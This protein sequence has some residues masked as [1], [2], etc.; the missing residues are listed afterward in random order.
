MI[1]NFFTVFTVTLIC[2]TGALTVKDIVEMY[3][4]QGYK[5]NPKYLKFLYFALVLLNI[6]VYFYR[7]PI[8][9]NSLI[10]FLIFIAITFFYESNLQNR[11][12]VSLFITVILFAFELIF[13]YII[14]VYFFNSVEQLM[15]Y[16]ELFS[17]IFTLTRLIPFVI[18]KII[19]AIRNI[20]SNNSNNQN[21]IKIKL[22]DWCLLCSVP[23]ISLFI[24]NYLVT[25]SW[26]IANSVNIYI[27]LIIGLII[28]LNIVFY[29]LYIRTL[30]SAALMAKSMLLD[31]QIE[32]Y[33]SEYEKL[34]Y[35]IQ[36]INTIKHDVKHKLLM[37][38]SN[39]ERENIINQVLDDTFEDVF[40]S[41]FICYTNNSAMDMVLN[42]HVNKG[43]ESGALLKVS[44]DIFKEIKI[45]SKIFCVVLGNVLDNAREACIL[46]KT[47]EINLSIVQQNDNLFI[48][49]E[50][51]FVGEVEFIDGLPRTTKAD[52]SIHGIGLSSVAKMTEENGGYFNISI[53]E[54]IFSVQILLINQ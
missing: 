41:G 23:I 51:E 5:Q 19:R 47:K 7:I 43:E 1:F 12:F 22:L 42:Y 53:K 38:L 33:N 21:H 37:A 39:V 14:N 6:L 8:V 31:K 15:K 44:T 49:C 46:S 29:Y 34:S 52:K 54:Q 3:F 4:T 50:N 36:E 2:T 28:L 9:Y 13:P 25:I 40:E 17:F 18:V 26:E 16:E 10:S 24:M 32:F 35:N 27:A 30:H 20:K 11:V 45:D 48:Q